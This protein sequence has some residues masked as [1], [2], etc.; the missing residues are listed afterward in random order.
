MVVLSF[1]FSVPSVL[2]DFTMCDPRKNSKAFNTEN[3]E[4]TEKNGRRDKLGT[5]FL[6]A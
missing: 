6:P 5:V 3:T 1:A 4:G 2:K